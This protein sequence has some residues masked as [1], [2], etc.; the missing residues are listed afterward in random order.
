VSAEAASPVVS[1]PSE[2]P[3]VENEAPAAAAKE[4][5]AG[6]GAGAEVDAA[7]AAAAASLL[8]GRPSWEPSSMTFAEL[9]Q[10]A[11][12]M[13]LPRR[14]GGEDGLGARLARAV[15][16]AGVRLESLEAHLRPDEFA[17]VLERSAEDFAGLPRWAQ[18]QLRKKLKLH[19]SLTA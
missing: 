18:Q 4:G 12:G 9:S 3:A 17:R 6:A 15:G 16:G 2:T 13:A 7:V 19:V 14:G 8:D 11:R 1:A 5:S 10:R